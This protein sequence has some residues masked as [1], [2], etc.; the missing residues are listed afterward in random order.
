MSKNAIS[1]T[2]T[3]E[4]EVGSYLLKTST[5]GANKGNTVV[6]VDVGCD[7]SHAVTS[8]GVESVTCYQLRT[9]EWLVDVQTTEGV[10][11]WYRLWKKKMEKQKMK[12]RTFLLSKEDMT[13]MGKEKKTC[14]KNTKACLS[15]WKFGRFGE[16]E[17]GSIIKEDSSLC[18]EDEGDRVRQ[19]KSAG[20]SCGNSGG[21]REHP[22]RKWGC[23]GERGE[24][25]RVREVRVRWRCAGESS[26]QTN[27]CLSVSLGRHVSAAADWTP[28]CS[29]HGSLPRPIIT[30]LQ[31]DTCCMTAVCSPANT[32]CIRTG[33][34]AY[35]QKCWNL[36]DFP[37]IR[38]C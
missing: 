2:P 9:A 7:R 13:V 12:R 16:A 25:K 19:E 26:C 23:R 6:V 22:S 32:H 36:Y 35:S 31:Q 10:I 20:Q 18:S 14:R 8:L 21:V 11:N 27:V 1:L 33:R 28:P 34:H 37:L 30:P 38:R 29:H 24:S 15:E 5:L 3:W 17:S 4:E